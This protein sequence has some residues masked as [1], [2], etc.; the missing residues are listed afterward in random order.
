MRLIVFFFF[1]WFT[2]TKLLFKDL[3]D[4]LL[5]LSFFMM[6]FLSIFLSFFCFG[7][8]LLLL[9]LFCI[10]LLLWF[11]LYLLFNFCFRL[12]ILLLFRRFTLVKSTKHVDFPRFWQ[13][14]LFLQRSCSLGLLFFLLESQELASF[15]NTH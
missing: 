7:L 14:F 13:L 12:L 11:L 3:F 10:Q 2:F 5:M 15:S 9:D 6:L 1:L 4:V 8:N